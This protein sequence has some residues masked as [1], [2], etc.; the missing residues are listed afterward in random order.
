[1]FRKRSHI[2]APL[3][4]QSGHKK[5]KWSTECQEA[6]DKAKAM[7]AKEAFLRYPD[8]NKPFHVY[9]DASDYQMGSVIMQEGKP[10]AFFSR[11][12][13][14]AQRNYTTGEKDIL[15]IVETLKEYRRCCS[16]VVNFMYTQTTA[17]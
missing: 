2:L 6:F 5:L 1:M 4:S 16:G 15:S 11:K 3:T 13:N 17:T 10:V 8:H 7:L 12:L 14:S 9:S